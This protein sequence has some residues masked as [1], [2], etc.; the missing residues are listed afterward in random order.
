[1]L[2]RAHLGQDKSND[3]LEDVGHIKSDPQPLRLRVQYKLADGLAHAFSGEA[4]YGKEKI[5]AARAE[6]QKQ[7]CVGLLLETRLARLQLEPALAP[8][9]GLPTE[10]RKA[11]LDA[12]MRDAKAGNF[13][14][15]V[16]LA[17]A[18]NQDL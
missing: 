6:T 17:E 11:Q 16:K 15:I 3:A 18:L 14:R 9:T 4:D 10:E 5:E 1:M 8:G 13:G 7:T 2:A 12:V